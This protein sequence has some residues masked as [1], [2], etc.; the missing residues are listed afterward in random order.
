MIRNE[1]ALVEFVFYALHVE[2]IPSLLFIVRFTVESVEQIL[3][4]LLPIEVILLR[5]LRLSVGQAFL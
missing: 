5:R 3:L 2:V 4:L 1:C